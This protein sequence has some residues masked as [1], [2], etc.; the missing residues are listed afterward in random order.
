MLHSG[1]ILRL[2]GAAAAAG[3][4]GGGGGAPAHSPGHARGAGAGRRLRGCHSR[5]GSPPSAAPSGFGSSLSRR[6]SPTMVL[7]S[8]VA[9]LLNRFLGDYVEN[10]NK[11]QLKLGIWG[12]KREGAAGGLPA[13]AEGPTP[14]ALPARPPPPETPPPGRGPSAEPPPRAA[15]A[16]CRE[17]CARFR[18]HGVPGTRPGWGDAA[19]SRSRCPSSHL[20]RPGGGLPAL[21]LPALLGGSSRCPQSG[22]FGSTAFKKSFLLLHRVRGAGGGWLR[23]HTRL[24][25]WHQGRRKRKLGFAVTVS[26]HFMA[27]RNWLPSL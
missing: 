21:S 15:G 8:V 1:R 19:G 14:R 16:G 4:Q 23:G 13:L 3:G 25:K 5:R 6:L 27:N 24:I 9:D 17:A 20:S 2:A 7:E 12:G 26:W 11:S 18:R 22:P 10:L